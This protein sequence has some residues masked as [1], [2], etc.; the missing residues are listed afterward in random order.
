MAEWQKLFDKVYT[1]THKTSHVIDGEVE[2]PNDFLASK[3][4]GV[5][6]EFTGPEKDR[7]RLEVKV[8][9]LDGSTHNCVFI[10]RAIGDPTSPPIDGIKFRLG[11]PLPM[12][13]FLR[14][15]RTLYVSYRWQ[16][17]ILHFNVRQPITPRPDL[18]LMATPLIHLASKRVTI[19]D[20]T[21]KVIRFSNVN[22]VNFMENG[23]DEIVDCINQQKSFIAK[24]KFDGFEANGEFHRCGR[25]TDTLTSK[26][27]T[28][29]CH[30]ILTA[31]P[32]I[33]NVHDTLMR[34]LGEVHTR[35]GP[36]V[37]AGAGE[38]AYQI[39]T[40]S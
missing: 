2:N 19:T 15:R 38:S 5:V 24:V 12:A 13:N 3:P 18:N 26:S 31:N 27:F 32:G 14:L 37:D 8:H 25:Q 20:V 29:A 40:S 9:T 10:M 21:S 30:E 17:G 6:W 39:R 23:S 34:E 7:L 16:G 22:L 4:S 28:L 33:L 36:L 11:F 35:S 1:S